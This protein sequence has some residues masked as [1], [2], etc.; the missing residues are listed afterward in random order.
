M[1]AK[2]NI[3][4]RIKHL[5]ENHGYTQKK[6]ATK[7]GL[8]GETAIANYESGYS[9]PKDEIKLKMCEIF[10]CTLDYLMC[11]SDD[12]N[13]KIDDNTLYNKL[14]LIPVLKNISCN[15]SL[16][17]NEDID[18]YLPIDPNM[19]NISNPDNYFFFKVSE[20]GINKL[21]KNGSY[22][23]IQM[24]NSAENEDIILALI[25]N[26]PILRRYK[27]L[28]KQFVMLEPVCENSSFQPITVD[29]KNET[30]KVIGK[31]IGDFKSWI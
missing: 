11:K 21:V 25:N 24:Q 10:N 1:E 23:L 7:L 17:R 2:N 29:L 27:K 15:S 13:S 4:N 3:G 14:F 5:R 20:E 12:L 30:L 19:Y 28:N 22:V 8:K 9:I 18:F 16:I 31:I 6:L 26:K